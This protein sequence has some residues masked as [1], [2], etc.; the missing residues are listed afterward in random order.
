MNELDTAY[1]IIREY[2]KVK[3]DMGDDVV[4]M[5]R[6]GDFY[7]TFFDDAK[8]M[9]HV[10][11]VGIAKRAGMPMVGIPSSKLDNAL[12]KCIRTNMKVAI[13]EGVKA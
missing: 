2:Q 11:G 8:R 12:D 3:S 7:E 6:V 9:A 1:P 5:I 13:L 10:L 4:A